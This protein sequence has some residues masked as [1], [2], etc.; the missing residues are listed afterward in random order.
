MQSAGSRPQWLQQ[1][2]HMGW[3]AVAPGPQSTGSV[4]AARG[5]SCS[6]AHEIFPDQDSNPCL[7]YRQEDSLPLSHQGSPSLVLSNLWQF[8]GLFLIFTALTVLRKTGQITCRMSPD[9]VLSDVFLMLRLGLWVFWKTLWSWS[10]LLIIHHTWDMMPH[11]TSLRASL[12]TQVVKNPPF[13]A[14]DAG[15]AGLI[16]GW[17]RSSWGG[18][19]NPLQYSCL[20]NPMDRGVWWATVH[21]DR[22]ESG[23]TEQPS[24]R[25]H[26]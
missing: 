2:Q 23:S 7:L 25:H 1:A 19:G 18:N 22:K 3:L 17:G 12:M 11:M 24:A 5:L 21:R 20:E 26:W 15:D 16:P 8:L 13:I 9:L 14:E 10:A 4:A 6:A